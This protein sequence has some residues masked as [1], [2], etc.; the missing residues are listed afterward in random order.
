LSTSIEFANFTKELLAVLTEAFESVQGFFLDPKTS[1]FETLATIT[2]SEASIPVGNK[3]ATIAAQVAHVNFYLELTERYMMTGENER[4]DWGEIW[5]TVSAVT[6]EEWAQS[7]ERLKQ[8][9][10]RMVAL[11]QTYEGWNT[12]YAMSGAIG[13]VAH[14]AYHL[15]EIRQA[16]CSVKQ[17]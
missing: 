14:T 1:L 5:R 8:T 10:Q 2:A 13:L 12:E 17:Q 3:C 6:P 9:Y 11:I 4:A 15:G 7:Q 16:T